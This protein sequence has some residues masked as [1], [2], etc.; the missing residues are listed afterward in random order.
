MRKQD[1]A[2]P[3]FYLATVAGRIGLSCRLGIS[4]IVP[5]EKTLFWP[6]GKSFVEQ[7]CLVKITKYLPT[8]NPFC[9]F[10][11]LDS[12]LVHNNALGQYPATLNEQAWLIIHY[13]L[14]AIPSHL[15][16]VSQLY[17]NL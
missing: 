13:L 9:I 5:L 15:Y 2:N 10:V 7:A 6:Y 12:N 1:E 4:C 16:G 8:G 11:N 14:T 3:V 17:C